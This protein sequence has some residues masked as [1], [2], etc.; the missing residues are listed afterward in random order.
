MT[1]YLITWS[2]GD[3]QTISMD[4][5]VLDFLAEKGFNDVISTEKTVYNL[6]HIRCIEKLD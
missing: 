1:K 5:T 4:D 3:T 6:N 2:N